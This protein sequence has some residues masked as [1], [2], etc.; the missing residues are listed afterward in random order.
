MILTEV[1]KEGRGTSKAKKKNGK[2]NK[3]LG[4]LLKKNAEGGAWYEIVRESN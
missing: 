2:D 4:I 1:N 3:K